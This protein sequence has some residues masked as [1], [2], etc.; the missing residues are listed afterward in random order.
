MHAIAWVV[1]E[2][3]ESLIEYNL[4]SEF[5][6]RSINTKSKFMDIVA[7]ELERQIP[8]EPQSQNCNKITIIKSA[9]PK[10]VYTCVLTPFMHEQYLAF[11]I[12]FHIP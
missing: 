12:M 6:I 10:C 4:N 8:L 3:N 11:G 9:S 1:V 7:K 5:G 2:Y